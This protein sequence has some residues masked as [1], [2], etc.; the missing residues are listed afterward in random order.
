ML[1]LNNII[2]PLPY[3]IAKFN[4]SN[5]RKFS[6]IGGNAEFSIGENLN[7]FFRKGRYFR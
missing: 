7:G 1:P 4:Y 3:Y 6:A 5:N 2:A